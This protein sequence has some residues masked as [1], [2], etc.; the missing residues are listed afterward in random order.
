MPKSTH[1]YRDR[2]AIGTDNRPDPDERILALNKQEF[3]QS[4][5]NKKPEA[6]SEEEFVA[7]EDKHNEK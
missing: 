5:T 6:K 1:Q 4:E 7:E 3:Q 2:D